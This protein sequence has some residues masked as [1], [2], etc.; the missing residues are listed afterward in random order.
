MHTPSPSWSRLLIPALYLSPWASA[1]P[2][3]SC[4]TTPSTPQNSTILPYLDP[5][6][7]IQDRLDDLLSRM[8]LEEKAGQLFIKQIPAGIN[9]TIDNSTT[10]LDGTRNLTTAPLITEKLLSHFNV[11]NARSAKQMAEWH[12]AIQELALQTRL[13]IPVTIASDPRHAFADTVGSS[14]ASGQFSKFPESLGIAALRDPVL[15]ELYA[16]IVREEY[17][18]VGIRSALQPQIDVVTEPRMA[19]SGQTFGEDANLTASMVVALIKGFQGPEL[20]L[21]SVTTVTKHFPGA[22]PARNGNDSHFATGKDNTYFGDFL[23]YHLIPFKAA[24][25][26]GGRQIMPSYAR[27]IGTKYPEVAFG[28]NKPVITGLL[29]EELGFDGIVVSDWGLITDAEIMGVVESARAWGVENTTELER[30]KMVLDAGVDQFGGEIRTELL[31]QLVNEGHIPESRLDISVRKLLEEKFMLGLFDKRFVDPEAA[32]RVVGN[33]Y[34]ARIGNETQRRA[35]TLLMNHADIL[36]LRP[37]DGAKFFAQGFN[38]SYLQARNLTVVKSPSEA[39]FCFLRLSTPWEARGSPFRQ[40]YHEGRLDFNATEKAAHSA[41]FK[42][43]PTIVDIL[44]DRPAVIPE[45]AEEAA[46]LFGHYGASVD[47][48]LDVVFNK[49]GWKPEGKLPFDMPRSM[50]AVEAQVADV[51]FDTE[52]PVFEFGHGLSYD[53][54]ALCG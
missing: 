25:A 13:K 46:A 50:E 35:Y 38:T 11:N 17:L 4:N 14:I 34:F 45:I 30:A 5:S 3:S 21:T 2:C 19:R 16:T 52:D 10:V 29:R 48:F 26:A 42:A 49:D 15:A 33:P 54:N 31:V 41:L 8:T 7:C 43:C 40:R 39:D 24:I 51:P 47:A 37:K 18:A 20:G 28:F 6:L 12:N 1:V 44:L 23:D 9:G 22:G 53:R 36:P 27:P 32:E